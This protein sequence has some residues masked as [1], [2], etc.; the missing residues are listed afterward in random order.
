MKMKKN[1]ENLS[2][3]T[4]KN[5]LKELKGTTKH[6]FHM[7]LDLI[8][9]RFGLPIVSFNK[10]LEKHKKTKNT[11]SIFEELADKGMLNFINS[12]SKKESKEFFRLVK[13][14][15]SNYNLGINW[16]RY[17]VNYL[18]LDF[19]SVPP[20]NLTVSV[21]DN[22]VT[23]KL[24]PNTSLRDIE[25]AW[26]GIKDL[27]KILHSPKQRKRLYYNSKKLKN[28]ELVENDWILHVKKELG[29]IPGYSKND[30][31]RDIDKVAILIPEG[32][33]NEIEYDNKIK[34]DIKAVKQLR[35]T[36]SRYKK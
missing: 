33:D 26:P 29:V 35:T 1:K 15:L 22:L 8:R 5:L 31:M 24:N 4:N 16:A 34:G 28:I 36:R 25:D 10:S 11:I 12:L 30:K 23:I 9:K 19:E 20:F 18:V 6:R 21:D 7:D 14:F 2:Y 32:E 27:Q 17:V 3:I 13:D